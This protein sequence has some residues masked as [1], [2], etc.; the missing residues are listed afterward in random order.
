ME[1]ST[2][3]PKVEALHAVSGDAAARALGTDPA[4]GLRR[5]EVALRQRRFGPNALPEPEPSSAVALVARQFRDALVL[6]LVGAAVVSLAL[7]ELLDG[8]VIAAIVVVNAALGAVQEGRAE[9]AARAVRTLLAPSAIAI[10]DGAAGEIAATELVPGDVVLLNAGDRVPADGRLLEAARLEIDESAMTGESV[11]AAKRVEPPVRRDAP[12]AERT[13]MALSGTTVTRGSA[14]LLVGATGAQTELA[15]IAEAASGPRTVTP[16]QHRLDGLARTLLR[17]AIV[18]CLALA[19]LSFAHG[20]S[21]GTSL[22]VGVSLAVAAVPEGLAAVVT[23]TLALGMRGLARR[24]AIVRRLRAVETLGSATVICTDKTGT[25]TTNRMAVARLLPADAPAGD[26]EHRLLAAALIASGDFHD[27]GEAAIAEAAERQ[28]LRREELLAESRVIGGEPFDSER[29]RMSVVVEDRA[30]GA[31]SYVKGAPEALVPRLGD[32]GQAARFKGE[33]HHWAG[34]AIRV[35][36]VARRRDLEDGADAEAELE[37]LGLIGLVDP[38]RDGARSSVETAREAGIR[39]IMITGDH[40]GTALAVARACAI[41][42]DS[43]QPGI[44][45]GPELDRHSDPQL[46]GR[47]PGIDVFARVVPE[48]KSRIVAALQARSEV[49]AMT[50]DG[51]NDAPALSSADIGV[52]MGRGGSDAAIEAAEIVL[53]DN[54]FSTLIGAVEGGRRIYANILRFINFLLGANAGEVLVFAFAVVPGLG[55]P[56]TIA[57]ILLVNLL[58]DGLPAVALGVDPAEEGAMRKPPRPRAQSLLR[59]L[60]AR[61]IVGGLATGT[62]AFAAFLIGTG[63]GHATGQT[64]AFTTVLFAQLGYVY[65]VRG[66]GPFFRAGRN[67]ALDVAVAVSGLVGG[68]ALA[69]P[70][71][72][73]AFGVVELSAGQLAATLALATLPFIA[74]ELLKWG[75]RRSTEPGHEC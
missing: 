10:R 45:T 6:L 62:A 32:R 21:L 13:T 65:A 66:D 72:A 67:R 18:I 64:M 56:L 49:V 16:L 48:H 58:T 50:G 28:G 34:D 8:A 42:P 5:R 57:Q 15:R 63:D 38:V 36:L 30:N 54:S 73:D 22:L 11:P 60:R 26:G 4:T 2:S 35:L 40:P 46:R 75:R 39:T 7:G 20:E 19:A 31:I 23:I 12:L 14:R 25:L 1:R 44:V 61:L 70:P 37:P 47:I 74:T 41:G 53:T 3:K 24:G 29:K 33:A 69:L 51:V 9:T 55:A 17:A 71:L 68:L 59:P 52:A 27:P 43:G